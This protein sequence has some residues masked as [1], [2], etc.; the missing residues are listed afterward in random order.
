MVLSGGSVNSAAVTGTQ[1]N[2]IPGRRLGR[3]GFCAA[4]SRLKGGNGGRDSF[5]VIIN[6]SWL[7][8]YRAQDALLW[9]GT[10]RDT[11]ARSPP[12]QRAITPNPGDRARRSAP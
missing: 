12:D 4:D 5:V 8:K 10:R 7:F 2:A 3:T 6:Y 11:S 9:R 1:P